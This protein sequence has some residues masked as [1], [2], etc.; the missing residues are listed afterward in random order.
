MIKSDKFNKYSEYLL[1]SKDL[2][3]KN[4]VV[5]K[6]FAVYIHKLIY[7]IT[8]L[9][10]I[11]TLLSNS[12]KLDKNILNYTNNYIKKMCMKKN[13]MSMKGG[14]A[15]TTMPATY[16]GDLEEA[17]NEVNVGNDVQGINWDG[18]LIR[19]QLGGCNNCSF[20]KKILLE[21]GKILKEHKI[22]ASSIIKQDLANIIKMYLYH[23]VNLL[24]QKNKTKKLTYDKLKTI[25]IK[26][27]I[28]KILN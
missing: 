21:I 22:K 19:N 27:K 10:C 9:V 18:G 16:F 5:I 13:K 26:N 20:N 12:N 17:Y 3:D 4:S 6:K 11:M 2:A 7:N 14:N 24:K 23:I 8:T 25:L 28:R 1:L 15:G